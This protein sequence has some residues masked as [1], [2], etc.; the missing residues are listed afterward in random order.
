MP[1]KKKPRQLN[2]GPASGKPRQVIRKPTRR[3]RPRL[4]QKMRRDLIALAAY[5]EAESPL[6]LFGESKRE[7]RE[8]KQLRRACEFISR[9]AISGDGL[10]TQKESDKK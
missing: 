1:T 4:T 2:R 8:A 5:V 3:R 9:L 6:V 7:R 10:N